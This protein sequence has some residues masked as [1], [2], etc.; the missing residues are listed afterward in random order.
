MKVSRR[1]LAKTLVVS[2]IVNLVVMGA[3]AALAYE[4]APPIPDRVVGPDGETVGRATA[5]S[6]ATPSGTSR[7]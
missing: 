3:G 6:R 4:K 7:R 2:F 1:T 5:P